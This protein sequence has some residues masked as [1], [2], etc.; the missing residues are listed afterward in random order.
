MYI[1]WYMCAWVCVLG[2][3]VAGIV[4]VVVYIYVC[5]CVWYCLDFSADI[6]NVFTYASCR[7]VS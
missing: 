5:V 4:L 1:I 6:D 7:V 2:V 3:S